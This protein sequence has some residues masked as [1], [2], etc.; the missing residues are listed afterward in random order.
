MWTLT[1]LRLE[2]ECGYYTSTVPLSY[3]M[4]HQSRS[5]LEVYTTLIRTEAQ[6]LSL[7]HFGR[8]SDVAFGDL[9]Q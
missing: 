2:E 5:R 6:L 7:A 8:T 3:R 1:H 4:F 9:L